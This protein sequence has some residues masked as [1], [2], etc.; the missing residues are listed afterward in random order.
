MINRDSSHFLCRKNWGLSLIFLWA[1]ARGGEPAPPREDFRRLNQGIGL[2][3]QYK[4]Q[5]AYDIFSKLVRE[6]PSWMAARVNLGLAA[7]NRQEK[8]FLEEAERAFK[9]ALELEPDSP[10]A[11]VPLAVLLRHLERGGEALGF[12]ERAAKSDPEDPHV[13]YLLG[14]TQAD[15][16]QEEKALEALRAAVRL[17]PSFSSALYRLGSLYARRGVE[18]RARRVEVLKDFEALESKEAGIKAGVKYGEA[19][20]Y[21]LAMRAAPSGSEAQDAAA[22]VPGLPRF[23]PPVA[24]APPARVQL[25]PDGLSMAPALALADLRGTGS[26]D[27][28]LCGVGTPNGTRAVV[29]SAD[30]EG[31][32]ARQELPFDAVVCAAGDL[33]GDALPD[34]AAA[35]PGRL[36]ALAGDGSGGFRDLPLGPDA[37]AAGGFPLRL[38]LLDLDSDGDLDLACL[39]QVKDGERVASRLDL[40]N[41][42]RDGTYRDIA[43]ASGL[44][45]LPFAAVELALAD[46]DGDVDLDLLL[47]DANGKPRFYANDRAW[48][49]RP[50]PPGEGL[51][52]PGIISTCGADFDGDGAQDLVL[53]CGDRLRFW[54]NGEDFRFREDPTF[55]SRHGGLG[56]GGGA[57]F[58]FWNA[59]EPALLVLDGRAGSGTNRREPFLLRSP[60]AERA[61]PLDLGGGAPGGA[62]T[63]VGAVSGAVAPFTSSGRP[64]LLL[65]D[66]V[67][68]G[69]LHD[70]ES[71][72]TWLALDLQGPGF[73]GK[74]GLDRSNSSGTG[75]TV[76]VRAG[77]RASVWHLNTGTGGTVRLPPRIW[78]GLAGEAGADYARVLWPDGVL[79]SELGLVAGRLHR[80]VEVERKDTSCPI[81]FAWD[82]GEFRFV[83]DFAGAGGLGYLER[84]G[85]YGRPDPTELLLLPRLEPA[86]EAGAPAEL[87]LRILEPLEECTYLDQASLLVVDHPREVTVLPLEIFAVKAPTPGFD[88]LAF[89]EKEIPVRA[90]DHRGEEVTAAIAR[91]DGRY[92]PRLDRDPRFA[93]FLREAHALELDF[94]EGIG[95]ILGGGTGRPVLFLRGYIEYPTSTS[96]FAAWQAGITARAPSVSVERE[97]KWIALREDWGFP[98]GYPRWMAVDLNGLLRQSDRR[99]RVETNLEIA[100]DG[101]FLTLARPADP[102]WI[103]EIPASRAELRFR[104]FPAE[105]PPGEE[106]FL[107]RDFQPWEHFRVMPGRYTR[108]GDVLDLIRT[109]DDRFVVLAAG[110]EV[111]L[112][113][114]A[115]GMPPPDETR[116][117]FFFKC[118]G[119]CKDLDLYTGGP[120]TVEPLPFAAMETYPP[121]RGGASLR[122]PA[123]GSYPGEWQKRVI[124]GGTRTPISAVRPGGTPARTSPRS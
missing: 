111:A 30:G 1:L 95:R 24:F 98:A 85:V 7:L 31:L 90:I 58:D 18:G 42:N 22:A 54:R 9:K 63:A 39:W 23:G 10:H 124:E 89:R 11:L 75:A 41:N 120:G 21:S 53:F 56:G 87:Q 72:G 27:V 108:Y 45:A 59:L 100:W 121:L 112:G 50:I 25:R 29:Y 49:Y 13:L 43:A 19:G 37:A 106:G 116:R 36:M 47:F 61:Q 70:L 91:E 74:R 102:R 79:Q 92:A 115:D 94:G 67:Q 80:L 83:G 38:Y 60:G 110:D 20:K 81:L 104:G 62:P 52:A 107:Y 68:G 35:G 15:L 78:C 97:G 40:L 88:L 65:Y 26:L 118:T 16:G 84:P 5:A 109:A 96:T 105:A 55:A 113:F 122:T 3:E 44:R 93:G 69:R 33:D 66:T 48:R 99:I 64:R 17:Q 117:A 76:E 28:V 73:K 82:G 71:S 119:Y 14:A 103:R 34:L 77:R 51:E 32:K 86:R 8:R 46:W 101:M 12:L 57:V 2:L 4:Y 6:H 114:P 123:P